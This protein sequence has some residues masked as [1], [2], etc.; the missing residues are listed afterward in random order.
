MNRT[1]NFEKAIQDMSLL[2]ELALATGQSLD[3]HENCDYFLKR[4]MG[5]KNLSYSAVWIRDNYLPGE[6]DQ[7]TATLIYAFPAYFPGTNKIST[8]HPLFVSIKEK[9]FKIIPSHEKEFRQLAEDEKGITDGTF[10]VFSLGEIGVVKL[11]AMTTGEC[12][13]D[14]ELNQMKK[15]IS[16]FAVSLKGCLSH[17]Q[18]LTEI[19]ER[20]KAEE[21]LKQSE[22][23]MADIINFL[24]DPTFA[25]NLKG[26]VISWNHAIETMTGIKAEEILGKGNYEY[27]LPFFGCRRPV[28]IDFVLK[29]GEEKLY[30]DHYFFLQRLEDNS[31]IGELFLPLLGEAGTFVSAKA[32]P[33]YDING[34]I[35]GAI[36][37]I[38]DVTKYKKAEQ[39]L[40]EA[41]I[42]LEKRVQERTAELVKVNKA[43]QDEI[44]DRQ[45][46]ETAL[47]EEKELLSVT[48]HSI[49]DG[50]ITTDAQGNISSINRVAEEIT[51]WRQDEAGGKP[52]SHIFKLIVDEKASKTSENPLEKILKCDKDKETTDHSILMV[53]DNTRKIISANAAPIRDKKLNTIIGYIITFRD[54]TEQK[55]IEAR[56]ALSQ[57]L[58][59]IGQ[60]AAG[61]AHEINTPMQ[62]IGD[63]T[64]FLHDALI[65]ILASQ[66]NFRQLLEAVE[67]NK[68]SPAFLRELKEKEKALDIDYLISEVPRAIEQTLEGIEKVSKIVLSMK[69]FAH[70]GRKEKT[71]ADLNK[72]IEGTVTISRNEW[73]Y[74]ADLETDF[75]PE[76]PPVHCILDEI[77]QVILNIVVNAAQAIRE[78]VEKGT[79]TRGVISV[80]TRK[81]GDLVQIV[82]SDNGIGI[83]PTII[84]RIFDPF[85]TTK[86]VGK[87]TGQGLTIAHDIVVNKHRGSIHVESEEGKG[88][89]FTISL[90]IS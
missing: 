32:T 6:T 80:K 33:L 59:S 13:S 46:A 58:E 19:A 4:L 7:N 71:P 36:E 88:T 61:I 76:L 87:G 65:D 30:L 14:T 75:D 56:L 44:A 2:Y 28:I 10:I 43:L 24:P 82:I 5:R 18:L 53:R 74:V 11:Y 55:K 9:E 66:E 49:G 72:A 20:K 86:D 17:R 81:V 34:K 63:N 48:L 39:E 60:L 22:Q 31:L 41:Q 51:G 73:K 27:A 84:D 57:K 15:V 1:H 50:V 89:V 29:P 12:F 38:R 68:V 23:Q 62:Y 37:A 42:T 70:P 40:Q 47:A 64:R 79:L 67:H 3:L 90:P 83:P 77:N 21:A 69:N 8:D 54:I 25:V 78:V 52:L 26:E 35:I 85:F 45:R 16:K